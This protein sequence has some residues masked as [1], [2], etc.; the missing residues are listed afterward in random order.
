[1]VAVDERDVK[2]LSEAI[3]LSR[4][5]D[6]ADAF[7]RLALDVTTLVVRNDLA[8][9]NE[10]DPVHQR[11][12]AVVRPDVTVSDRQQATLA[13]L[14]E[15]HPL[16]MYVAETG[17]GSAV[18]LSDFVTT[19]EFH[20][21][22]LY[23][24]LFVDLGMEH[25]MSIGLPSVLPRITAIALNRNEL[26]DDFDERDRLLL[27]LLRPH[28]A[29]SYEQARE[30]ERMHRRL[31]TLTGVLE[32]GGTRVVALDP[33]PTEVTPGAL[34][35]LYRYFG[36]PGTRAPFPAR[37]TRWLESQRAA[38]HTATGSV[39]KPLTSIAAERAG[40][41]LVVRYLP[42]T[43]MS[44]EALLLD[45]RLAPPVGELE[46]LGLTTREAE[47]LELLGSG[48]TNATLAA[49]LHVSPATVKSHLE[50]IYRK[51][52][53][54]GRVAAVAMALELLAP[55]IRRSAD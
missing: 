10:I 15:E 55:E 25:Q 3:H 42:A 48:A 23:R 9:W 29:Q 26:G 45:E 8:G 17:D 39:P 44:H 11:A 2:L 52:G 37:L 54:R 35:L 1:M 41:K 28:L 7:P 50:N 22:R 18:R 40:T 21:L 19:E 12:N 31:G 6:T 34:V 36:R 27:N 24:E 38:V 47:V 43:P 49:T 51:L 46:R 33:A 32:E 13:E 14:M 53:V 5:V 4:E 30:R 16:I 20:A